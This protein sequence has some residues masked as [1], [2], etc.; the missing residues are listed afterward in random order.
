MLEEE[1][2]SFQWAHIGH[3]TLGCGWVWHQVG[4]KTCGYTHESEITRPEVIDE[5]DVD[6]RV[7]GWPIAVL[8][9]SQK[10]LEE[11]VLMYKTTWSVTV[12]LSVAFNM[13]HKN[14]CRLQ[15]NFRSRNFRDCQSS[16][17]VY[18]DHTCRMMTMKDIKGLMI[19]N[20]RVPC[21]QNLTENKT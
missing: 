9:E 21:L 8:I 12:G 2:C 14:C 19:Q 4:Y 17:C 11:E 10:L 16:P 6:V 13:T 18:L 5:S 7:P 1:D 15:R 3:E 20:W